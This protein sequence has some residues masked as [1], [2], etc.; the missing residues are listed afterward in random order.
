MHAQGQLVVEK[1][2]IKRGSNATTDGW[3]H[4]VVLHTWVRLRPRPPTPEEVSASDPRFGSGMGGAGQSFTIHGAPCMQAAAPFKPL[5]DA[6]LAEV[7][8]IASIIDCRGEQNAQ[9]IFARAVL[10]LNPLLLKSRQMLTLRMRG[11][12]GG[13]AGEG[14][15]RAQQAAWQ[16]LHGADGGRLDVPRLTADL[17]PDQPGAGWRV[18]G[19][20]VQGSR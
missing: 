12:S 7:P 4:M 20:S 17:L 18:G 5:V 11:G 13:G 19:C 6:L 9:I 3:E 15:P 8:S 10:L 1:F 2:S 16:Q 14:V